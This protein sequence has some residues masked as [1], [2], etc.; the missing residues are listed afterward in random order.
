MATHDGM[1]TND[2]AVPQLGIAPTAPLIAVLQQSLADADARATSQAD[3]LAA[4]Q[5]QVM[6]L[7]A[8]VV[9]RDTALAWQREA[10]EQLKAS[11][12]GLP[13]RAALA[14][15]VRWLEERVQTLMRMLAQG[16]SATVAAATSARSPAR[17][18]LPPTSP[19]QP[20]V[21]VSRHAKVA[22]WLTPL[23]AD[24]A[25]AAVSRQSLERLG[26]RVM[27]SDG[28]NE[29]ELETSLAAA[30]LVICQTGCVSHGAYWR[31]QDHCQRTGKQCV[32]VEQPDALAQIVV[33]PAAH[34]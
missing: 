5:A 20:L 2:D 19:V 8:Q 6:Q 10:Y 12:P 15:R 33:A 4:L 22:L 32:L 17:D 23:P 18:V 26:T 1:K 29:M 25:L 7:R 13:K 14:S 3:A 16:A 9:V 21:P 27:Q 30:D 11:A 24:N 28:I 31:V 34:A